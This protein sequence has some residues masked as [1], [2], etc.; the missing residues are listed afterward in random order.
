MADPVKK[1]KFVKMVEGMV[2]YAE[3]CVPDSGM[4]ADKMARV[5][6]ML[7][8]IMPEEYAELV[9]QTINDAV[10]GMDAAMK[11]QQAP[12]APQVKP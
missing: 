5:K 12:G 4:G 6:K 9:T 3:Y 2:E 8:G 10:A 1:A 11:N 7:L